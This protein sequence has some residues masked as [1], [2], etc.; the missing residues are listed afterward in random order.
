[1]A[2]PPSGRGISARR[3][4]QIAPKLGVGHL[5]GRMFLFT[6]EDVEKLRQRRTDRTPI[7]CHLRERAQTAKKQ[8]LE[9]I[10]DRA[11]SRALRNARKEE[12][13]P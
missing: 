3:V 6:P 9:E 7:R 10:V 2:A 8:T 5:A 11:V 4:R 13:I 12:S 1:M